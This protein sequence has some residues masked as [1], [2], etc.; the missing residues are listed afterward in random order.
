MEEAPSRHDWPQ[1]TGKTPVIG[2]VQRKGQSGTST[3]SNS[4]ACSITVFIS[5]APFLDFARSRDDDELT[6]ARERLI[7]RE[8]IGE[9]PAPPAS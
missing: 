8:S 4:E 7:G 5:S 1:A 3:S 2:A 6:I 9:E